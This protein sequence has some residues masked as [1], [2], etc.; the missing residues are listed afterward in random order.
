MEKRGAR[1]RRIFFSNASCGR[2]HSSVGVQDRS[3]D[4]SVFDSSRRCARPLA[5]FS[6]AFEI[7]DDPRTLSLEREAGRAQTPRRNRNGT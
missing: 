2:G 1:Q 6:G 3:D 5:I 4:D 7:L